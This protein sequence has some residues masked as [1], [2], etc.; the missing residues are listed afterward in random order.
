[1]L[2]IEIVYDIKNITYMPLTNS[3]IICG[4]LVKAIV[5]IVANGSCRLMT[6]FNKSFKPVRLPMSK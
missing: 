4:L 3:P 2:E 1:V 6:A 5:G